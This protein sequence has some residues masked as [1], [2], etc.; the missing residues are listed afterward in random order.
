MERVSKRDAD[1]EQHQP[2]VRRHGGARS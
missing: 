1:E 2:A